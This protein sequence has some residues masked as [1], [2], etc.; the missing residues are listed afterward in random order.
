MMKQYLRLF[1]FICYLFQGIQ[2]YAHVTELEEIENYLN[3]LNQYPN[4]LG[5]FGDASQYEIE[6]VRD[7]MLIQEI[8]EKTNRFAGIVYQDQYWIW[9]NDPVKFPNGEYGVY[10]RLLWVQSLKG[11]TGV[12]VMPVL[13]DGRIALNRNFRHATRSWEFELPRGCIEPNETSEEAAKRETQEETGLV[14]EELKLLGQM[15]PD[16]GMTND[17]VSMYIARVVRQDQATPEPSEAIAEIHFFT[18]A[19]IKKGFVEGSIPVI[20]NGEQIRIPLRDP[21]LAY[22]I[23]LS[24][25]IE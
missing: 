18:V 7:P 12:A 9:L 6:I 3:F 17:L 13:S 23:L 10:G 1:L 22:A 4:T 11:T 21:F 8:S 14:I 5:P 25:S 20:V 24:E 19:E 15:A 16:S 2:G